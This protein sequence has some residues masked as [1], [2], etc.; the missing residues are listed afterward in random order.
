MLTPNYED[1]TITQGADVAIE[2]H[3]I[4]DSDSA[5]DLTN[6][7]VA[8]KMKRNYT[9]SAGDPD[10]VTFNASIISPPTSGIVN[11]S[12]TNTQTDALKTRGRYVYD[13]EISYVDSDSNTI[14]QRVLEGQAEVSP[15][16]TK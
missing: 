12:L 11:L 16:V 4:N 10:T 14:I 5:Y 13:V 9:D 8:S 15:S 6:R 2:I 7:S 3:L 1:I